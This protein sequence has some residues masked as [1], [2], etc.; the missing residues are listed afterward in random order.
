MREGRKASVHNSAM[1]K[2]LDAI[3]FISIVILP[4]HKILMLL[5]FTTPYLLTFVYQ[6]CLETA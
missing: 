3:H 1:S 5:V 2:Q 4:M 6:V